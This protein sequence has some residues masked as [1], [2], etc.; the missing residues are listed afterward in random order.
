MSILKYERC[1][2]LISLLVLTVARLLLTDRRIQIGHLQ[3]IPRSSVS[4]R[5]HLNVCLT[6]NGWISLL[7]ESVVLS[8][9][10]REFLVPADSSFQR[11][12]SHAH[13]CCSTMSGTND[14]VLSAEVEQ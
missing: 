12:I 8:P 10:Q 4:S 5:A 3:S 14:D 9:W 11:S 13:L 7:L 1:H 6:F 2:S